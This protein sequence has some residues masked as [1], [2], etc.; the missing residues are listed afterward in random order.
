MVKDRAQ[1]PCIRADFDSPWVLAEEGEEQET[2]E[3]AVMDTINCFLFGVDHFKFEYCYDTTDEQFEAEDVFGITGKYRKNRWIPK[4]KYKR[5]AVRYSIHPCLCTEIQV[6][7][8]TA[9]VR[10]SFMKFGYCA[11]GHNIKN[12]LESV[13]ETDLVK[14]QKKDSWKIVSW[15]KEKAGE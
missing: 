1:L 10:V 13:A 14:L 6:V 9:A 11:E 7:G 3:E 5:Q 2:E 8:D 12:G 4:V 15:N